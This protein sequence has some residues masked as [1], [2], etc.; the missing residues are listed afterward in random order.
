MAL[1]WQITPILSTW[2]RASLSSDEASTKGTAVEQSEL[3]KLPYI[4]PS[5][6]QKHITHNEAVRMLDALV[7]IRVADTGRVDPPETVTEGQ[8][9]ALG[10]TPTGEFSGK[11]GQIAAYQDGAWAF[12]PP[13]EGWLI[14]DASTTTLLVHRQGDWEPALQDP[15]Q[16]PILG[17]NTAADETNRLSVRSPSTLLTHDG[18]DHRLAINKQTT[19]DTATIIFQDNWS[20]RTE[21]GLAGNDN[22]AIKVSQ[23]GSAWTEALTVDNTTGRVGVGVSAPATPLD[24]NGVITAGGFKIGE[25]TL[26]NGANAY[27]LAT[28]AHF[29]TSGLFAVR[30]TPVSGQS[31]RVFAPDNT[32]AT[33]SFAAYGISAS[34]PRFFVQG[35]G[36]IAIGTTPANTSAIL[37]ISSTSRGVLSPRMTTAQRDAIASPAAGLSIY[38]TT[39]GEPQF[40]SGTQWRGPKN[41]RPTSCTVASLP[42]A[43]TAG[44]IVFVSDESGGPVLAFADGS[45]WRR[46]T[47]RAI[48]S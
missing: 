42:S 1:L 5:Q 37:D 23:N 44:S 47:D 22:F 9:H 8:R 29:S 12:Y 28:T 32:A 15:V 31:I 40:W 45:Q 14:W 33:C 25:C 17:I 41:V 24:V 19:A 10:P 36:A 18:T 46:V 3:L 34:Q 39:D 2:R 30:T 48:V 13:V 27:Q 38:N 4:M 26:Q 35:D 6:A 7:H 43:A 20:A 21:I 11:G 16:L